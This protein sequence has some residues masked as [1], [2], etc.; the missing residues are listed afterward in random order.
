MPAV[1]VTEVCCYGQAAGG[2]GVLEGVPK[3]RRSAFLK[4][5]R[6][7]GGGN[8][9]GEEYTTYAEKAESAT[10]DNEFISVQFG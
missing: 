8:V 3:K 7:P 9:G 1:L 10:D 5:G 2:T 4:G 6:C